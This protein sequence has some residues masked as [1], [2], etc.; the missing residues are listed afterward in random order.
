[1]ATCATFFVK[2]AE[3]FSKRVRVR[4]I[5][6]KRTLAPNVDEADLLQF[7]E[8]VGKSGSW[9][10]EF[11]LDFACD[12]A[13]GVRGKQKPHDLEARLRAERGKTVGGAGDKKRVGASHISTIAEIW[14]YV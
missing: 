12:H 4:G 14:K 7:F 11:A 9:D 8:M 3:D 2:E 1:M 13:R 5:P 6:K 10:F